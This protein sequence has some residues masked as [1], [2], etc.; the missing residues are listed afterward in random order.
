MELMRERDIADE[1]SLSS[2]QRPIL[3]PRHRA[4]E[5]PS[6]ECVPFGAHADPSR[7]SAIAARTAVTMF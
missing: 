1:L 5:N 4:A 7:I 2:D 6:G 3:D